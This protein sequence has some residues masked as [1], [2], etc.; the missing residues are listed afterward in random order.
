M[1]LDGYTR[2][3]GPDGR[4][5][6]DLQ[7]IWGFAGLAGSSLHRHGVVAPEIFCRAREPQHPGPP[8]PVCMAPDPRAV[9]V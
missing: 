8:H 5:G 4:R 9:H 3:T 6:G 7:Q 2:P 1:W